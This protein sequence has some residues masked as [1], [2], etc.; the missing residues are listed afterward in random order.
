VLY[1]ED[2][3]SITEID[4]FDGRA[5]GGGGGGGGGGL[6]GSGLITPALYPLTILPEDDGKVIQVDT[7]ESRVINL[8]A[9]QSGFK[10]TIVDYIGNSDIYPITLSRNNPADT[11]QGLDSDYTL[12]SPYGSWSLVS[13]AN[14]YVI[15]A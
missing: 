10:I 14:G 9:P 15:I 6:A 12:E 1:S 7:D 3:V 11:I 13:N 8:P 2:G 4:L 5:Y